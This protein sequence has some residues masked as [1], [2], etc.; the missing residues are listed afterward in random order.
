MPNI[1]S[2]GPGVSSDHL[3]DLHDHFTPPYI[4]LRLIHSSLLAAEIVH[5]FDFTEHYW[6]KNQLPRVSP[7][8]SAIAR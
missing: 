4:S 8:L 6:S 5:R 1:T 7:A 2:E 3:W